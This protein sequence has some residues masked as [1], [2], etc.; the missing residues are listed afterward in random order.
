MDDKTRSIVKILVA[1]RGRLESGVIDAKVQTASYFHPNLIKRFVKLKY[2]SIKK[3]KISK[4][5]RADVAY[6]AW[7]LV[8]HKY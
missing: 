3:T 6:P 5:S 2:A 7:C 8:K 4:Q 1:D